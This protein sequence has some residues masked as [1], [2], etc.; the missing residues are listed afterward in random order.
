MSMK[1]YVNPLFWSPLTGV[2]IPRAKQRKLRASGLSDTEIARRRG[3]FANG[4]AY[5]VTFGNAALS[6]A[7]YAEGD[8]ATGFLYEETTV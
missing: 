4:E 6:D 5:P 3:L 1:A 7:A 2:G 8:F